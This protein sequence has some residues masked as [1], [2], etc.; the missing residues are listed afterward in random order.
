MQAPDLFVQCIKGTR[1]I[2]YIV[3]SG[4]SLSARHLAGDD[5]PDLVLGKAAALSYALHL[6]FLCAVDDC[7]ALDALAIV[8]RFDE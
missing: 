3:C 1:V 7:N 5:P 2:D 8:A 4:A 6:E